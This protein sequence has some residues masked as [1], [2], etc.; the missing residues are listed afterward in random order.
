VNAIAVV[1]VAAAV[2]GFALV[3]RPAAAGL[4][5]MP[6]VFVALG[7]AAAAPGWV[8]LEVEP[9]ALA[10]LGEVTLGMILF[11]DAVRIDTRVLR[12]E[13]GMPARLLGIGL[14]LS[15]ALG[16]LIV[17]GVLP[18]MGVAE[19]ALIAVILAPT[20]AALGQAVVTDEAV[21]QRVRQGLNV[22]S[23]LND[24]LVLPAVLVLIAVVTGEETTAG[25]WMG[26]LGRQLGLGV[27]IGIG[28]G[29]GGG[30]LIRRGL[31]AGRVEG[32]YAQLGTLAVAVLA[33]G[34]AH[35]VGA[36]GFIAAFG[37]GLAFGAI[38]DQ[39]AAHLDEYTEDTGRLLAI[40]AFFVFGNV[41]VLSTV[42][43]LSWRIVLCALLLLT[44]GRLLPVAISLIGFDAA[45]PTVLFVGW[46]GPRGLASILFGLLLLEREVPAAQ[47]F[48]AVIAVTVVASVVLHGMTAA[49]GA[50]RYGDWFAAQKARH[51]AMPEAVPV[52]AHRIRWHRNAHR[53]GTDRGQR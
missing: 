19:A 50:R 47:E 9:E 46:F 40:V 43:V 49:W 45:R 23:G 32:I 6:M 38:S 18:G 11:G 27:L 8:T 30:W 51:A 36:N 25:S 34:S 20:D 10:L 39:E 17:V 13:L 41:F 31:A 12:R 14:P 42:E 53:A 16:T 28:V 35:L 33:F 1:L 7:A 21:P 24:G 3:S 4:V 5:T 29:V 48:F 2:I 44:V 52:T 26:L 15:V 22:E 37:A